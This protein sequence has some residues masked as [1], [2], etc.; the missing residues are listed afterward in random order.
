[1]KI[2][3]T[4]YFKDFARYFN[5][6]EDQFNYFEKDLDCYNVSIYPCSYHYWKKHNKHSILLPKYVSK[7]IIKNIDDILDQN[8]YKKIDLEK[9]INFN[10]QSQ[11]MYEYDKKKELKTQ[12]IKY[13][14][15]FDNLFKTTKFDLFI[16]SGDSRMLV[17]ISVLLAKRYGVKVYYFEQGPFGT[18]MIDKKGVNCNI[19]F[20]DRKELSS[21]IDESKLKKYID[22]YK[23]HKKEKYWKYEKRD[24]IDKYYDLKTF[25]WMYPCKYLNSFVPIDTQMGSSF[26]SNII[27]IFKNKFFQNKKNRTK[28]VFPDNTVT[29]IMQVPIDAQLIDN[30][31]L[32]S[33]FLSMLKDIYKALPKGYGLVIREHPNY[34]NKYDERIYEYINSK[35]NIYLLNNVSLDETLKKSKLII[36]NNS[37]VGIEALTYYKTVLTLGDAYY[38]RKNVT[39]NLKSKSDLGILMQ[40]ALENPIDKNEINKF[41]YNF[42]FD[43]LIQG[44]FQDHEINNARDV[45]IN[46]KSDI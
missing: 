36:L 5:Y 43:Y 15:F 27:P 6:L 13:I 37:T 8:V 20:M 46:V 2:L 29:F 9:I 33:D 22:N 21:I 11:L 31:P 16:S 7:I 10:Y 28:E 3:T 34:L 45:Y 26:F 38:N 17:E 35:D 19:S 4:T 25:Y 32:Y 12:A 18:T 30:S 44:H 40:N 39:Y 14:E 23:N 1:M 24:I 41:L 42:I